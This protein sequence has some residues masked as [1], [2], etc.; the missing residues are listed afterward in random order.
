MWSLRTLAAS[1]LLGAGSVAATQDFSATLP[2]LCRN[3]PGDPWWPS[4]LEWDLF[5]MT[6]NGNLIK[7]VPLGA[8][9]HGDTYNEA[10]CKNLQAEWQFEK[11][12]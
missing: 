10:A 3:F 5:N 11:I 1:L 4:K 2:K 7:T 9:C 6:V 12:Q 8:P